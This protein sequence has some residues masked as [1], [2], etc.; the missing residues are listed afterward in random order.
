VQELDRD[1]GRFWFPAACHT[2]NKRFLYNPIRRGE[3]SGVGLRRRRNARS[4][5]KVQSPWLVY[6]WAV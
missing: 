4:N 6:E 5:E 1:D 3:R 2:E